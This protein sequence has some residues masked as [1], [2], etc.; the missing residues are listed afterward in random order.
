LRN[1]ALMAIPEPID[2]FLRR[3]GFDYSVLGHADDQPADGHDV[4]AMR[5]RT[6]AMVTNHG[7]VLAV[8]SARSD[9]D[10]EQLRRVSGASTVRRAT[11]EELTEHY[12]ESEP[13]AMPPLGPLYGQRVFVDQQLA[14][15][16]NLIFR[17]GTHSDWIRMRYR[18]FAELVHPTVGRIAV[19]P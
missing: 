17:G 19:E 2:T 15:D 9:V 5:T 10:Q 7:P 13:G 14:H 4:E 16:G 18:D 11:S 1:I 3:L 8:V 6:I 12:P